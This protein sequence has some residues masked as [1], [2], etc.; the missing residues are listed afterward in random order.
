MRVKN[1]SKSLSHTLSEINTFLHFTQKFKMMAK[2]GGK[3]FFCEK[4]PV[5]SPDT[6]GVQNFV[7]ISISCTFSEIN[8]FYAEIQHDGQ[9]KWQEN[10]FC[11]KTPVGSA[12]TLDIKNFIEITLSHTVSEIYFCILCRNSRWMPKM[13]GFLRKVTSRLCRHHGGQKCHRNHSTSHRFRDKC[14]FVF[15]TEI[16]DGRQ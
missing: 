8:V 2:N 5:D 11:E 13:A 12:D 6:L 15:Y 4:L 10:D 14:I 1:S 16:Q 7:E 3:M 9:P